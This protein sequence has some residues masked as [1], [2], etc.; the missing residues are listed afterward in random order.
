[1]NELFS[2][3]PMIVMNI[4]VLALIAWRI[5]Q[6]FQRIRL[7]KRFAAKVTRDPQRKLPKARPPI[8]SS[9]EQHTESGRS[10]LYQEEASLVYPKF[11]NKPTS[12]LSTDVY[13]V[14]DPKRV[15]HDWMP[16]LVSIAVLGSALFV[17]LSNKL[18]DDAQ[19]KWAFGAVGTILGYWLKK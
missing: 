17:I 15:T 12:E 1:M 9:E 19:Q 10:S 8:A 14:R 5:Y 7:A 4:G 3:W 16:I 11:S 6:S 18:Y 13:Q 2:G